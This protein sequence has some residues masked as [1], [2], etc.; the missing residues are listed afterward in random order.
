MSISSLDEH[1]L[2]SSEAG[3]PT[4]RRHPVLWLLVGLGVIIVGIIATVVWLVPPPPLRDVAAWFDPMFFQYN[5]LLLVVFVS[6]VPAIT[7]VYVDIM[8]RERVAR[9]HSDL[10]DSE[11]TRHETNIRESIDIQFGPT[12]YVGS[13]V[14]LTVIIAL[15]LAVMLLLKPIPDAGPSPGDAVGGVNYSKGANLLLLGPYIESVTSTDE[16]TK[17]RTYH[18][19]IVSLTAFQFGFLGAY[20]F[21][22][23]HLLRSYFTLDLSPNT[24]ISISGRMVISSV[25]A[26]VLSFPLQEMG[27]FKGRTADYTVAFLPML[28]FFI[29]FFPTTGLLI[30]EKAA[31]KVFRVAVQQYSA[32]SLATLS[33]MSLEHETRLRRE[34]FDNIE[35]LAEANAVGLAVRTGFGYRQLRDWIGEAWLRTHL[36]GDYDA[37]VKATGITTRDH[38]KRVLDAESAGESLAAI[39]TAIPEALN[40]KVRIVGRLLDENETRIR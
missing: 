16:A 34:G 32:T 13:T 4:A 33:G 1:T 9:L 29:G 10:S 27:A 30:I 25:T 38:L 14:T 11:W 12:N 7:L 28:S 36:R 39:A 3:D 17:A 22:I 18:R 23:G 21:F 37:F 15:F 24:Y 40:T 6:M 26:L 19:I 2:R 8:K 20:V 31:A 35:N 5:M